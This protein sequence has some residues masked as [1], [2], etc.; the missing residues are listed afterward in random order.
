MSQRI[1]LFISCVLL[2]I[3]IPATSTSGIRCFILPHNSLQEQVAYELKSATAVFAGKVIAQEYRPILNPTA[4]EPEGSQV[5]ITKI[6]VDRWWKGDGGE[7]VEMYTSVTKL[8]NGLTRR[9]AEDFNFE[10]GKRY[11]VYA[12]G[13]PDRL[14]TNVCTLTRN[15]EQT[16]D[17]LREL[18]E[19][20]EPKKKNQ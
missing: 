7:E 3:P 13:Q 14:V 9:F 4:E 2:L 11:L 12:F 20:T 8:P 16:A 5:L 6:S 18:G 1:L 19:G 15:I 17:Q 10:L